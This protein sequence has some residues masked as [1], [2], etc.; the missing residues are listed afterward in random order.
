MPVERGPG[1]E[2]L[3]VVVAW[4]AV[5]DR[6]LPETRCLQAVQE[7]HLEQEVVQAA[8]AGLVAAHLEQ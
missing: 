3:A 5:Q 8:E 1:W 6:Q 2:E 4:A 7:R